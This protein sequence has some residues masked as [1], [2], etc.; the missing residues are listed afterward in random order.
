MIASGE[1]GDPDIDTDPKLECECWGLGRR[2]GPA[3]G[4]LPNTPVPFVPAA[5]LIKFIALCTCALHSI[6][7]TSMMLVHSEQGQPAQAIAYGLECTPAPVLS[8]SRE[9]GQ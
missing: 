9:L 8:F 2:A 4:I 7:D 6:F 3:L 1:S 5:G